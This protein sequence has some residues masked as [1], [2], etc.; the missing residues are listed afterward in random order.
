MVGLIF[1]YLNNEYIL[2]M[3][4]HN[5]NVLFLKERGSFLICWAR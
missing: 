3:I 1:Y 2:V 5:M 4:C